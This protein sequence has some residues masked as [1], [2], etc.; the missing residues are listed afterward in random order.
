MKSE[1]KAY[2]YREERCSLAFCLTWQVVIGI[3]CMMAGKDFAIL[4][5]SAVEKEPGNA[6]IEVKPCGFHFF[7]PT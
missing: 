5:G 3:G 4:G 7:D 1:R 6:W 2:D